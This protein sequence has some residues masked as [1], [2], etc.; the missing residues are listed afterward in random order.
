MGGA[1]VVGIAEISVCVPEGR[2]TI[3]DMARLSGLGEQELLLEVGVVKKPVAGATETPVSLGTKAARALLKTAQVDPS[4]IDYVLFCGCG[5]YDKYLWSPAAKIQS[6]LGIEGAFSFEI[7]NGCNAGNLGVN[8]A[9]DLIKSRPHKRNA[10]VIVSDTLS[11][12][13]NHEDPAHSCLYNFSD[14]AGAILVSRG[15]PRNQVLAFAALTQAEFADHMSLPRAEPF[16]QMNTDEDEDRRLSRAYR[17]NYPKVILKALGEAGLAT[18]DVNHLFINQGDQRL[19]KRLSVELAIPQDRI[20][21]SYEDHGHMGGADVFFGMK[22]RWD[23][24][25]IRRGDIVVLASSAVGFSWG[26]TVL[27]A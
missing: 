18:Q 26:A 23:Q 6:E 22:A 19:I 3:S 20:H 27:R 12:I 25:R 17:E 14:A 16:I 15:E 1:D 9:I 7:F 8:L 4:E 13:V 11:K 10:L 21:K 5:V 24:G 2:M